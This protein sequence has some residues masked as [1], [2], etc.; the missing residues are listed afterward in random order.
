MLNKFEI[1]K[2]FLIQIY[3]FNLSLYT[4]ICYSFMLSE[5]NEKNL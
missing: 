1:I 3:F 4:T 2:I 5:Q